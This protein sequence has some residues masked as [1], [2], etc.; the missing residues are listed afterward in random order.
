M[1]L[2]ER[3]LYREIQGRY[4][5]AIMVGVQESTATD[6]VSTANRMPDGV[7]RLQVQGEGVHGSGG[8]VSRLCRG[9][10]PGPASQQG[11]APDLAHAVPSKHAALRTPLP[12]ATPPFSDTHLAPDYR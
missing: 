12:P 5:G 9:Y 6:I 11:P 4:H 1:Q 7:M 8:R 3:H 10:C 2:I